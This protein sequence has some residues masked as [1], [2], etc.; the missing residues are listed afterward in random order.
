MEPSNEESKKIL[1][2]LGK[3]EEKF[4]SLNTA[5]NAVSKVSELV[6]QTDSSVKSAHVRINDLKLD[7]AKE[8]L[9]QETATEKE[10]IAQETLIKEK[11]VEQKVGMK[12]E[13]KVRDENFSKFTGKIE[14][15]QRTLAGSFITFLFGIALY[16]I[17]RFGG[18]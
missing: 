14:F 13:F 16:I 10:F 12:E 2:S 9:R 18:N 7:I 3:L 8:I 6:I 17:Q 11:F 1:V 4:E 5:M 15:L